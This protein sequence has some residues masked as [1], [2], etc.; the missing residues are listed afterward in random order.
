MEAVKKACS[1]AS[2]KSRLPI[3]A[4]EE[5]D[6]SACPRAWHQPLTANAQ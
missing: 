6:L 3:P 2:L 1:E 4:Y 5:K